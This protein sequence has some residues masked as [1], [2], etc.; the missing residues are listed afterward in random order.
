[1][2]LKNITVMLKGTI[3]GLSIYVQKTSMY[4]KFALRRPVE[5]LPNFLT[6]QPWG[7]SCTAPSYKQLPL[8]TKITV[9]RHN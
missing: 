2:F 5:V 3:Y 9:I 8:G 1:M 7:R 6:S 4:T